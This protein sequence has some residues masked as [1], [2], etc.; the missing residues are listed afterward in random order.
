MIKFPK[1]YH[2]QLQLCMHD[3][4]VH[5]LNITTVRHAGFLYLA[6]GLKCSNINIRFASEIDNSTF[7]CIVCINTLVE[8]EC[9]VCSGLCTVWNLLP[10]CMT[11]M[12]M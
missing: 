2:I 9:N 1:D 4:F 11:Y 8:Q 3:Q 5:L 7:L 10:K 6:R 12:H